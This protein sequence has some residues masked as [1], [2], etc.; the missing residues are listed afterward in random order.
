MIYSVVWVHSISLGMGAELRDMCSNAPINIGRLNFVANL[1]VLG[2][3]TYDVILG[4]DWLSQYH[5]RLDCYGKSI[6]FVILGQDMYLIAMPQLEGGFSTRLCYFKKSTEEGT[7]MSLDSIPIVQEFQYIFQEI[8]G[9]PPSREIDFMIDLAPGASP[10][11]RALYRISPLEMG[12]LKE[13]IQQLL[14]K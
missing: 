6:I 7:T 9:L 1:L 13:K 10:I 4:M 2:M 8:S 3:I 11:A 14:G 5:A 12:E